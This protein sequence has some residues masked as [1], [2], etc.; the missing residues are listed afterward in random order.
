[1]IW[2]AWTLLVLAGLGS[3]YLAFV[4]KRAPAYTSLATTGTFAVAAIGALE[5]ETQFTTS[6]EMGIAILAAMQSLLGVVVFIA[7]L[8]GQYG[9]PD[10][11][12]TPTGGVEHQARGGW[13]DR[14][15]RALT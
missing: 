6:T 12:D 11:E 1:M 5:L 13:F 2:Q 9:E 8:T 7:A 3:A 15:A 10:E 4:A 14:I